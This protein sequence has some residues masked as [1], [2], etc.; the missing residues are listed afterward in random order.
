MSKQVAKSIKQV[1]ASLFFLTLFSAS[2]AFSSTSPEYVQ[3]VQQIANSL[4][5]T[6][7][8]NGQD[9][10]VPTYK[11]A[12]VEFEGCKLAFLHKDW[13]SYEDW[14]N[15]DRAR[16]INESFYK[17][18]IHRG[19]SVDLVGLIDILEANNIGFLLH[20]YQGPYDAQAVPQQIQLDTF[21]RLDLAQYQR[22]TSV[23]YAQYGVSF[24]IFQ[25]RSQI[26]KSLAEVQTEAGTERYYPGFETLYLVNDITNQAATLVD[27]FNDAISYC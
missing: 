22:V 19:E 4:P 10:S 1:P 24:L 9:A 27:V 17:A 14:L 18:S 26:F 25:Q 23:H 12:K 7:A 15:F 2:I 8:Q 13:N 11:H 3:A 6:L 16:S 21:D 20:E 5:A